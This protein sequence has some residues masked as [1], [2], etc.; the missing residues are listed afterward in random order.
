[1]VPQQVK[2]TVTMQPAIPLLGAFL[3]ELK[4]NNRQQYNTKQKGTGDKDLSGAQT[5]HIDNGV[6]YNSQKV[7]A[8]QCQSVNGWRSRICFSHV[9]ESYRVMKMEEPLTQTMVW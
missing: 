7:E 1:M 8:D 3:K 4:T 2:H 9:K 6:V 5:P